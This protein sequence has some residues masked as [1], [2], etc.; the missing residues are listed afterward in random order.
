MKIVWTAA[1]WE[2]YLHWQKTDQK[3]L[4]SIND[5]IKDIQRNPFKGLGKPEP[6]KHQLQ[7]WWS[8]RITGE[9]R[10]VYAVAGRG[11]DQQ[12]VVAQCRYHY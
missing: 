11:A 3:I 2:D 7:G 1:A 10:L 12:L 4:G 5:L 9:H 6:L 8:R